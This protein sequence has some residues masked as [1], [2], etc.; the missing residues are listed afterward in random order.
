MTTEYCIGTPRIRRPLRAPGCAKPPPCIFAGSGVTQLMEPAPRLCK[1]FRPSE[2]LL[3][4]GSLTPAAG[5]SELRRLCKPVYDAE[6]RQC[7]GE[8]WDRA[9]PREGKLRIEHSVLAP[10]AARGRQGFPHTRQSISETGMNNPWESRGMVSA[11]GNLI[12]EQRRTFPEQACQPTQVF[13]SVQTGGNLMVRLP[14]EVETHSG[15]DAT[16]AGSHLLTC[17]YLGPKSEPC[18]AATKRIHTNLPCAAA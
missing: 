14:A 5:S 13:G 2:P 7:G 4:M 3:E 17:G 6:G 12:T 9:A 11:L 15:R 18:S 16:V 10:S 8:T 1:A